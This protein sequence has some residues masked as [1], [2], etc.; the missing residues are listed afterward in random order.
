MSDAL[1]GGRFE[2]KPEEFTQSF[3]ASLFV[4]KRM[5]RSDIKASKAH[6]K[7]LGRQGIISAEDVEAILAG[8][9]DIAA[10]IDA[11]TFVF[12]VND[13][14]IHMAVE[15][16]LTRKI[17]SAGG[18]L[19]T[20]RSRNDQVATDTRLY[21]KEVLQNLLVKI[22]DLQEALYKQAK[23][24]FGVVMPGYTHMQRAQPVLFSHHLLAYFWMFA[25]DFE[26]V[27]MALNSTDRLP[28]GSAALAGTTYPLDRQ[29]VADELGFSEVIPNS[30]D[31][32]SDRDFLL[33]SNYAC[34]V[35]MIHLSRLCEELIY[36]SSS[37]FGFVTMSDSYS[38]GSSIMPQKKNP[39]FAELIRG[40]SGRVVGDLVAL[41]ITLK[42][43]PLCYNKDMQED[44]EGAFDALDTFA[45]SLHCM[46]GMISTIVVNEEKMTEAAH[47]GFMAAT[48]L[49][50][51]LVGKG[52]AFREAHNIIGKLVLECEK[53]GRTL[54]SFSVDELKQHCELFDE[55][56]LEALNINNIVAKRTTEGG[57][58]N[59]AVE[60]QMKKCEAVLI[61]EKA[62]L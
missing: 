1:W 40:K 7:M 33:D 29:Y 47:G 61:Q 42:S 8:L 54:Q 35:G 37:E 4:D 55:D 43:L 13:E 5:W 49:A 46:T 57:T 53:Q 36:W 48:D 3:G 34:S 28:L 24:N 52:V 38:T 25:R 14:D 2:A 9:D 58:G 6:A 31:A 17:G 62:E 11:G 50:D 18:R 51:Y 39:D 60:E 44:K 41:L 26:R 12:D 20:A 27:K 32:V 30:M 59:S 10:E 21:V 19:H 16:E 15:A 22:V 56:A 23:D 45:D